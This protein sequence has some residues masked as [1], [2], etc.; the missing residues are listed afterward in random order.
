MQ[1]NKSRFHKSQHWTFNGPIPILADGYKPGIGGDSLPTLEIPSHHNQSLYPPNIG[2]KLPTWLAYDKKVL[3]FSGY[4]Q[5]ALQEVYMAPYQVRKVKIFFYL[6]DDTM[7]VS[8][9]RTDNSGIPQGCLVSR[10]RIPR[11]PP[12]HHEFLTILD[13]NVNQTVQI[14][15]R[16]YHITSCDLYT[17]SFLNRLG[18]AVPDP[19]DAPPD[20]SAEM[21]KRKNSA[22]LPKKLNI[23]VDTF[24]QFLANDRKVLRFYGYWDDRKNMFGDIRDLIIYYFLA[25]DT[26]EIKEIFPINSG[27]D[28]KGIFLRRMK[29]PV[30]F[31]GIPKLGQETPFT[32]LNVLGGGLRGGRYLIDM[33]NVGS[34]NVAFLK[35]KDLVIGATINVY[36]RE[37]QLI[38]CD[39][40]TKEYYRKVYGIEDFAKCER[41]YIGDRC[42]EIKSLYE[43]ELPPFNGWGSHEDSEGN[44]R[45][46]EPKPPKPDFNKFINLDRYLL[47]FGAKMMSIFPENNERI[48]IIT[49]YLSD[50]TISVHEMAVRNSGFQGGDFYR[51]SK[52]ILPKQD[53]LTPYRPISYSPH[54]FFIGATVVLNDF[55]F[56]I[57]S[58]DEFALN[59]MEKHSNQFPYSNSCLIMN[60]IRETVRPNY[61][62]FVAN[63]MESVCSI[64][65]QGTCFSVLCFD[66]FKSALVALL[67]EKIVDHEIITLSRHFSTEHKKP[68]LCNRE[69]V[70]RVIHWEL[71][72]NLW[73]DL[74]RFKEHIY[75]LDPSNKG[76]LTEE[77]LLSG[78][79]ANRLPLDIAL[80]KNVFTVYVILKQSS[81]YSKV[82]YRIKILS[83]SDYIEMILLKSMFAISYHF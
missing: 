7:Q 46:V 17:R 82:Q 25:D 57:A 75:Y 50:D 8:E 27:R 16:V 10:Q 40:Y 22:A 48:F 12:C 71:N 72:R 13:L 29:I 70:R 35:D 33:L 60:K 24:G 54:H 14:F 74:D 80:I 67:G 39:E 19:V 52:M 15:D 18:I 55:K 64:D 65:M 59:Y 3:C 26:V 32:V 83:I 62:N 28:G 53:M 81:I 58:A 2:P 5:E 79:R 45:T 43:R 68:A 30:D 37:I 49:Y 47:R 11:P 4:F 42:V 34:K 38:D 73:N 20:P 44:C 51:R 76:F 1:V 41:P 77:R 9:P 61:K 69:K 6:E 23:K 31:E 63:I 78:I 56:Y 36:G 21:R 66:S